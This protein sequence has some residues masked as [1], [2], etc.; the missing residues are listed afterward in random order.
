MSETQLNIMTD[1]ELATKAQIMLNEKGLDLSTEINKYLKTIVEN[2]TEEGIKNKD[3]P[4][5][6]LLRFEDMPPEERERRMKIIKTKG[7]RAEAYGVFAGMI[8][9][10][11]DFDAPLI[12]ISN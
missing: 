6:K 8:W 9:M 12:K 3:K 10:A 7:P 4:E 11:D 5:I 2:G 1:Y